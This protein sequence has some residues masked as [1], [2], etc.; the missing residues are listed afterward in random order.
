M[1]FVNGPQWNEVVNP[2]KPCQFSLLRN[3]ILK[4]WWKALW[5]KWI[6]ENLK[7]LP[8]LIS[9]A[10][11]NISELRK[12]QDLLESHSKA[13]SIGRCLKLKPFCKQDTYDVTVWRWNVLCEEILLCQPIRLQHTDTLLS[14]SRLLNTFQDPLFPLKL[15]SIF[16]F[17]QASHLNNSSTPHYLQ[18]SKGVK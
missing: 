16:T 4:F 13:S 18:H 1:S 7:S 11:Q 8:H 10:S 17:P 9:D 5:W 12:L 6:I 14:P 2:W 3:Q 15:S